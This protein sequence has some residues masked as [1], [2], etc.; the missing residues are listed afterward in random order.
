MQTAR[1]VAAVAELG[2][3][4]VSAARTMNDLERTANLAEAALWGLMAAYFLLRSC[5]ASGALRRVFGS[6]SIAFFFFGVSDLIEA[7]TGAWWRPLWLLVLKGGCVIV[8][9]AGFRN[10]YQVKKRASTESDRA[11]NG[12]QPIR[13][14]TS[15]TSSGA[16]V[17]DLRVG[18]HR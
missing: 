4:G 7:R 17:A 3:F 12:N 16:P 13:S 10:Y 5:R 6:L 18:R 9:L 8:L 1:F 2:A 11:S 15:R 14:E